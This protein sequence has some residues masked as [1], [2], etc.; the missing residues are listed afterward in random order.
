MA[1][2]EE[3]SRVATLEKNDN[4]SINATPSVPAEEVS[5]IS[6][7]ADKHPRR[8]KI[9]DDDEPLIDTTAALTLRS[10]K[11][12]RAQKRLQKRQQRAAARPASLSLLNLPP[13]LVQEIVTYLRP[14]DVFELA[15]VSGSIDDFIQQ[16]ESAIA[17][18]I[19][20][21]RYL[22][23]SRCFPLPIA[24]DNVD[25]T[26]YPSLLSEKH[27]DMLQIHKKPYQHVKG[28]DPLKKNLNEREPIPMIPRGTSPEWNSQFLETNAGIVEKAM[29]SPL[30][31]AGILE[32][33]LRTTVQT[34]LRTF[35]GKKTVHPK[36]L[37]HLTPAEANKE[38]DAFLERSGP[39]S[40][41]FPWHRDNYYGLEAYVPNR[42]WSKEKEKWM[43]YAEGL[44]ERDLQ[45]I[46]ERFTGVDAI[47]D[48]FKERT[49]RQADPVSSRL[50]SF[51]MGTRNPQYALE[52]KSSSQ[53]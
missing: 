14:S 2:V 30:C 45:W 28:I 42:K 32:K 37:Y 25:S 21:R 51:R 4:V 3:G 11:T 44:H 33:H 53:C 19:I 31:Y 38:S 18:D 13:E 8:A 24:F 36:R 27:Q 10:K 52:N 6:I 39:P 50:N 23:L 16:H 41:E 49:A 20:K 17:R 47:V 46:K 29:T 35:R 1:A 40:Y 43:Y 15:R 5:F 26:A 7:G 22:V 12:D 48:T 34:I 9:I